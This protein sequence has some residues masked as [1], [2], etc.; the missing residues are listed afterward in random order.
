MGWAALSR[1]LMFPGRESVTDAAEDFIPWEKGDRH[2]ALP[3]NG[4]V[5]AHEQPG[6]RECVCVC[7]CVCVCIK[8]T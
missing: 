3:F 7:V 6:C 8:G 4:S 1:V 2:H 5:T